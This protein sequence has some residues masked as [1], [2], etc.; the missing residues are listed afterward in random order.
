[1]EAFIGNDQQVRQI[2]EEVA[3]I[4]IASPSKLALLFAKNERPPIIERSASDLTNIKRAH[5]QRADFNKVQLPETLNRRQRSMDQPQ[6]A[7]PYQ[8]PR[9]QIIYEL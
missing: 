4:N 5:V 8:K 7:A 1:M 2:E 6:F 9:Y 3:E